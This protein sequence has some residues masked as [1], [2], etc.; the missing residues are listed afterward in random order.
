MKL[1]I[2]LLIITF[3]VASI[4]PVSAAINDKGSSPCMVMGLDVCGKSKP[5]TIMSIE[6]PCISNAPT[7]LQ[8]RFEERI[9]LANTIK[10]PFLPSLKKD[11]PP[12]A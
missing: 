4:T 6:I 1:V 3:L 12:R 8:P 7:I 5:L 11:K 2:M 10:A 9:Y